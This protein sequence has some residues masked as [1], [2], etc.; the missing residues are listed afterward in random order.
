[1]SGSTLNGKTIFC[2]LIPA[3][4]HYEGGRLSSCADELLECGIA[5][6]R[7]WTNTEPLIFLASKF[8]LHAWKGT[9]PS[10]VTINPFQTGTDDIWV[11]L[12]FAFLLLDNPPQAQLL[13]QAEKTGTAWCGNRSCGDTHAFAF[14]YG[15]HSGGTITKSS[16]NASF[17][18]ESARR[19]GQTIKD[20]M[21]TWKPTQTGWGYHPQS[22]LGQAIRHLTA[23][24]N[25]DVDALWSIIQKRGFIPTG[26]AA[27]ASPAME[28]IS[29][30]WQRRWVDSPRYWNTALTELLA[31][32][33]SDTPIDGD[34]EKFLV[35]LA[36]ARSRSKVPFV[37]NALISGIEHRLGVIEPQGFPPEV[38]LSLTGRCNIEC[39]FCGY[40]HEVGRRNFVTRDNLE[41]LDFLNQLQTLRLNSGLGEPT[42]ARDLPWIIKNLTERHPHLALN[43]F[44]NGIAMQRDELIEAI[45][46]NVRWINVSLNAATREQWIE[47]CK[48]DYFDIVCRNIS[49]LHQRKRASG[50]LR[51]LLYASMA[52]NRANI[53][54][55]PRMPA[56]CRELGIDRF[57]VFPYFGL[58]LAPGKFGENMALASVRKEYDAIYVETVEQARLHR[59]TVELPQPSESMR[60]SFGLE[61]RT[62][63]DFA[64]VEVNEW[65]MDRFLLRF[66]FLKPPGSHCHFLWRQGAIGSTNN[67]GHVKDETHFMYPCIGPLSSV[68]LSRQ[69]AFRFGRTDFL[70]LWQNPVFRHLRAAQHEPRVCAVCDY[71]R[72]HD[73]RDPQGFED[74]ES[75]VGQFKNRFAEIPLAKTSEDTAAMGGSL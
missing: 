6:L 17:W 62:L 66:P 52:I 18:F 68:D 59:V 20:G 23:G 35:A 50:A 57:T 73:T 22:C 61:V 2:L 43:F 69:T 8:S 12:N 56:L 54:E 39:R 44:T 9:A 1:M 32:P 11:L 75:L 46:G 64:G 49:Q 14:I 67:G 63:Y 38:H 16:D 25:D 42:L 55:L 13:D 48:A 70:T 72:G 45:I 58:G 60:T 40:T 51:P 36:K 5:L 24:Q 74:L 7:E 41:E 21:L 53:H 29:G 37:F 65:P 3:P 28:G 15:P 4:G 10:L 30:V 27:E 71:C 33:H 26:R 19:I 47:Q 34:P 31:A